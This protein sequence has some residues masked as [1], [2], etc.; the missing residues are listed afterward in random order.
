MSVLK[1][2]TADVN[3]V[4]YLE[5]RV[6]LGGKDTNARKRLSDIPG[7]TQKS[8]KQSAVR[9][10]KHSA[11]IDGLPLSSLVIQSG[12]DRICEAREE[13]IPDIEFIPPRVHEP[14]FY[15]DDFERIEYDNLK[16]NLG[17]A[18][19]ASSCRRPNQ[20]LTELDE[21][22]NSEDIEDDLPTLRD[23]KENL[24][25]FSRSSSAVEQRHKEK[26]RIYADKPTQKKGY[27]ATTASSAAKSARG[28]LPFAFQTSLNAKKIAIAFDGTIGRSDGRKIS[29]KLNNSINS[30][31][32][33]RI[34]AAKFFEDISLEDND[35]DP[36]LFDV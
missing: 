11:K 35:T 33:I 16:K 26:T 15:P 3:F 5:R 32:N 9:R 8:V 30:N 6:P 21:L 36:I 2:N 28:P 29:R 1:W 18:I 13:E 19:F 14:D 31:Q 22:A 25:P 17:S 24:N 10:T 34:S 7:T 27:M 12:P 23:Q 4:Y 20:D